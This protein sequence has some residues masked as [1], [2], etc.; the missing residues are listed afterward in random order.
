M[1][2]ESKAQIETLDQEIV[3]ATI[4]HRV[5]FYQ[6]NTDTHWEDKGTGHCVYQLGTDGNPDQIIVHSEEDNSI[7]LTSQVLKRRLYQ[8]QQ[9]TLIVWTEDDNRDL[10][11]SFQDPSGCDE[12]WSCIS[13][14]QGLDGSMLTGESDELTPKSPEIPLPEPELSNLQEILDLLLNANTMQ[15]K[16]KISAYILTEGYLGKLLSLFETCE[17]LEAISD[18]HLLYQVMIALLSLNDQQ[19]LDLA[20]QDDY[21]SNVMGILEYNPKMPE[22]KAEHREFFKKH[23]NIKAVVDIED[24]TIARKIELSF[25]LEYLQAIFLNT[26]STDEGLIGVINTMIHQN[27]LNIINHIQNN[28]VLL[29]ELFYTFNSPDITAEKRDDIIRFIHQLFNLTKPMEELVRVNAL[30]CLAPHGLLDL[31]SITLAHQNKDFRTN[32]L[33]ILATFTDLDVNSVRSHMVIQ[34]KQDKLSVKP[35][36][37]VVVE[38]AAK[39][40][41]YDLKV[42]Y[43]EILRVLLNNTGPSAGPNN[44]AMLKQTSEMDEFLLLF[45]EKYASI[46]F[47]PIEKLEI[48]PLSLKGPVEPLQMSPDQAQ[49]RLYVCEF[50][51]FAVRNHGFHSKYILLSSDFFLR[52]AQLYR[53]KYAYIKLVALKFFRTCISL[54]DDFYNRNLTKHNIFEP[55]IRVLLDT[56]SRDCLLNSACLDLLEFIRKENI[57]ILIDHLVTQFG[58]V[59]DTITYIPT[60]KLLRLKYEQNHE[61]LQPKE[62]TEEQDKPEK[63]NDAWSSSNMEEEEYFN[64]SDEEEAQIP[65]ATSPLVSYGDDEDTE[66]DEDAEEDEIKQQEEIKSDVSEDMEETPESHKRKRDQDSNETLENNGGS[67]PPPFKTRKHSSDEEEEEEDLLAK[68]ALRQSP[69]STKRIVIKTASI[70]KVHTS[71]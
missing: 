19:L 35:L 52:V 62:S 54:A 28:H 64:G 4:T 20:L 22:E 30:R 33:N 39:E 15:E 56:D 25:R 48:K 60:C 12:M 27:H 9:D 14:K 66:E 5:K 21:I 67:S 57:K 11:L 26:K 36:I 46:L 49:L 7:L 38:Q 44:E 23:Q 63:K 6:L 45:Y 43:F 18:L 3:P 69:I 34:S 29:T 58:T 53:S 50:L 24:E 13:R 71:Q 42:Q 17:D 16:D 37:E 65:K 31:L 1:T 51:S 47:K 59:L 68:C 61:P 10:A 2:E 40:D 41:D 8:R 55:T 70:K 32:S